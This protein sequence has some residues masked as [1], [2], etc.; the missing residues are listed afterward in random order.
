M[1]LVPNIT[2]LNINP[3]EADLSTTSSS[4]DFIGV[5]SSL[6]DIKEDLSLTWEVVYCK[7]AENKCGKMKLLLLNTVG[8]TR[9]PQ[10]WSK[11]SHRKWVLYQINTF[12]SLWFDVSP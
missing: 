4:I 7:G 11:I 2:T 6:D 10:N 8:V 1:G 9:R 5:V 3:M 12:S